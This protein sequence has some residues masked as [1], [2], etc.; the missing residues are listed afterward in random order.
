MHNIESLFSCSDFIFF[1]SSSSLMLLIV[2]LSL[3]VSNESL[4]VTILFFSS[5]LI[6]DEIFVIHLT[7]VAGYQNLTVA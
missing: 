4:G 5:D 3:W 1:Q 2:S 6:N 7:T